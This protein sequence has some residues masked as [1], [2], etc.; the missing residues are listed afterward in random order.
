MS[1]TVRA[2]APDFQALALALSR[3][4]AP[5]PGLQAVRDQGREE[6]RAAAWP[7]RR[8]ELWKYTPLSALQRAEFS[9]WATPASVTLAPDALLSLDALR[10]VFVNGVFDAKA[11]DC[12]H[13]CVQRFHAASET[14]KAVIAAHLGARVDTR[15]HLFA[16]LNNAWV[17]EGVLVHVPRGTS[18]EK[19][20]Y[21]VHVSTPG[22][23][24][25][26]VNHRVL[27]VLEESAKA[28]LIE[29]F[30]SDASVQNSFVNSLTELSVGANATLT[31]TRMNLEE[32][33]QIHIGGVHVALQRD[34]RYEGFTL[35]EGSTL[36]RLDYQIRHQGPGAFA[37]LN[38][39]Y[40][41][42]HQQL[43]DYHTNVEHEAPHCTTSEVFRGIISDSARAVFNGRIHIHPQAQKTLAELSNR[44]LLTSN[45]AEV[46]T[47][48]EL[49][50]YADDVR[51]AHGATVSQLDPTA[52]F[53]L[54]S[55][56]LSETDA[57]R[58]L[59]VGFI[60]ELLEALPQ[61]A[62]R[63]HLQRHLAT[64]FAREATGHV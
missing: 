24:A 48:P 47:K 50:I 52:M 32:E 27:V 38:G 19:P 7:T 10:L 1:E 8:T 64:Q 57:R 16:S 14:Q 13:P 5:V 60:N 20:V 31:H 30:V 11:S 9:G 23:A 22:A 34:A 44:N 58:M 18:L 55:R 56:G 49:E 54:Q 53:Y 36:K 51:C 4:L 6:W 41:P 40:M 37:A 25:V 29:H 62:V 63:E 35:A 26:S 2:M 28:D 3:G 45:T 61:P 39:V 12:A 46:D 42:R 15:R 59:S 33:H 17:D 21:I 43:L